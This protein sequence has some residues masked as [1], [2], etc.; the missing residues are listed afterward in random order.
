VI[1]IFEKINEIVLCF[2]LGVPC[3][4]VR[5]Y[6]PLSTQNTSVFFSHGGSVNFRLS[7]EELNRVTEVLLVGGFLSTL[8]HPKNKV[9][10]ERRKRSVNSGTSATHGCM[11]LEGHHHNQARWTPRFPKLAIQ[12]FFLDSC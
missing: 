7:I 1:K 4:A 6:I 8:T 9:R 10:T 3:N 12:D 11:H 5:L 2:V